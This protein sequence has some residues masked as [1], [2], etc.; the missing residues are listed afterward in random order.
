MDGPTW[1]NRMIS[2]LAPRVALRRERARIALELLQRHYEG[3]ATGRRTQGWYRGGGDANAVVAPALSQL[4]AGA[5]D[6]VRN[7]GNAKSASRTITNHVVGWGIV[8]KPKPKNQRA[9]DLWNAWAGTTAC[10]SDGQ[11]DFSGLQKLVMRTVIESGEVLV[12]RRFRRPEDG[13]PIPLQLQVL[14]PDYIDT[15]KHEILRNR[16][17]TSYGRIIHGVEFNALGR[18]VAYWLFREHPGSDTST[19]DASVRIP[20]DGIQHVYYKERPGQVRG[21]SWFAPVVL[22]FKDHDEF[23]DATLMKQKIAACLAV[24]VSD[25]DGAATP[26]GTADTSQSPQIDSLE[27]GWI[28]HVPQGTTVETIAPPSVRDYADY[29]KASLRT[30]AAGLGVTYEDLTG[31]YC[32]A[33]ETRVLRAD[34]RWVRA[35]ELRGGDPIVAFDEERPEGRGQRRKWRQASVV[36]AGRRDLP[37]VRVVTDKATVTVSSEHKFLCTGKQGVRWSP[38]AGYGHVWVRA[39]ELKAGDRIA[40]L[41]K[42]WEEGQTHLHGYL[43]GIADGEGWVDSDSAHIGIAQNPG[44]VLDEIGTA[45]R[46]LGFSPRLCR[47]NGRGDCQSWEVFG[48]AECLRFLGEV[49]PTRLL[50]KAPAIYDGKAMSGG[51]GKQGMQTHAVVESAIAEGVGLVVTLSTTTQTV[52]TEGLCSHN[53]GLPFS[54]ARMSRIAHWDRVED[55]RWQM[56]IPQFCDPAWAWAMEAAGVMGLGDAPGAL[57]TAPPMPMIE[58]DKE[59]LAIGRNIRMGIDTLSGSLRARG[60]DPEEVF[61]EIAT[62]NKRLDEMKI[63]LDSDPRNTTQQGNPRHPT[64]GTGGDTFTEPPEPSEPP[65]AKPT[66][67]DDGDEDDREEEAAERAHE[68]RMALVAAAH[69]RAAAPVVLRVEKG[70]LQVDARTTIEEGA[71]H[72]TPPSVTIAKDAVRVDA[73]TTIADGAV[74]TEVQLP[75]TIAD[76]V[77]VPARRRVVERDSEGRITA[78]VSEPAARVIK[79]KGNRAR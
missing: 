57:W 53:T 68:E 54:A 11:H 75:L 67:G 60:Y 50:P 17:G 21:P 35:D 47:A 49:R 19:A 62:D 8:A 4:R 55:W 41:S 30:I 18:R 15:L 39:D 1:L 73:R 23:E 25:L 13:L 43:K 74:R 51:K 78:L 6:L 14:D 22:R 58:P 32:I 56:L 5:R 70:A 31:D 27:P 48:T 34:L 77:H 72:I 2:F 59:G 28:G 26:L 29:T 12:R 7:N 69:A 38:K 61:A 20:S 36:R 10:D 66:A 44:A 24:I 64:Q 42:P 37:R 65:L 71:L 63:I 76:T 3:A 33:P 40:F 45:L 46:A 52:I 79:K 16:D 9:A